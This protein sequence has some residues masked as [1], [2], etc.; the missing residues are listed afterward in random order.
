METFNP[1]TQGAEYTVTE[2]QAREA[3]RTL[4]RFA[5]DD[6]DREGLRGTPERITRMYQEIFRGYRDDAKPRITTFLNT[7]YEGA[8]IVDSGDFYSMCEHHIL[9]FFGTYHF[10]YIP[11]YG[12]NILGISKISR[13][14]NYCAARLQLQE[15]LCKDVVEMLTEAL[16]GEVEGMAIIMEGK[17][18]CKSMR[19]TKS[20][21][22]MKAAYYTGVFLTDP[23]IRAEFLQMI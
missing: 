19:G 9:P 23:R 3:V 20:S 22:T 2:Q 16:A 12:G 7:N 5:G 21:G 18:L 8:M 14:V 17:H 1:I 10:A 15:R 6:P 11:T 4:I 13:V